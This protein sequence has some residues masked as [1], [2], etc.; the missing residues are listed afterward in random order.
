MLKKYAFGYDKLN[1][2]KK[3]VISAIDNYYESYNDSEELPLIRDAREQTSTEAK[4][5]TQSQ[6][7]ELMVPLLPFQIVRCVYILL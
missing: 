4:V 1:T 2:F 3:V 6:P 5:E 7:P